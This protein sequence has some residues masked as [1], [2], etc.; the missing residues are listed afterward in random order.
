MKT[1][2]FWV[3]NLPPFISKTLTFS[4]LFIVHI[5]VQTIRKTRSTDRFL[6]LFRILSKPFYRRLNSINLSD[7][8]SLLTKYNDSV[9]LWVNQTPFSQISRIFCQKNTPFFSKIADMR[10]IPTKAPISANFGTLMGTIYPTECGDRG[11]YKDG[12]GS[13]V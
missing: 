10:I 5:H 6:F 4:M 12:W 8:F 7:D 3:L 1:L 11:W 13:Q 9:A 2:T